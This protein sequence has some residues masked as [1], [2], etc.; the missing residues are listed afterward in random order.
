MRCAIFLFVLLALPAVVG[1]EPL[2]DSPVGDGRHFVTAY[3]T[4]AYQG[5]DADGQDVWIAPMRLYVY[6]RR[7]VTERVMTAMARVTFWLSSEEAGIFRSRIRDFAADSESGRRPEIRFDSDPEARIYSVRDAAGSA[8]RSRLNGIV[9][10]RLALPAEHAETLLQAQNSADGWLT[11]TVTTGG[12]HQGRG[13][14]QLIEPEGLSVISDIDDTVKVTEIPAGR[15]T[16]V[17]NTFFKAYEAAPGMAELYSEW[18][19]ATFHYVSG[20]PWQLYNALTG[21]LFSEAAGFPRGSLHMKSVRKNPLSL[22]TWRDLSEL[23]TN[24]NVTFDQKL[25]Q[26]EQ[27]LQHFPQRRFIL[28]GD[29]GERDPEIYSTIRE[30]FPAQVEAIYIRDVVNDRELRPER[31]KGMT[32]IAA[33]TVL[34]RSLQME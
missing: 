21:F 14:V 26:I 32:I 2:D 17:R 29:S 15:R 16:V 31:L 24:E 23:A 3:N 25:R 7:R 34:H 8:R 18:E 19:D 27:V 33:P 4:Y 20:S 12:R 13:H 11:F 6:E 9:D 5:T 28:V 30:R 22:N 1:T 10:G